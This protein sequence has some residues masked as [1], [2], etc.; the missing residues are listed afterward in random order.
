MNGHAVS[1]PGGERA[2]G[3]VV[4]IGSGL[5]AGIC[6]VLGLSIVSSTLVSIFESHL[7]GPIRDFWKFMPV[8]EAIER[9]ESLLPLLF[10]HHGH[11]HRLVVPRLFYLAEYSFFQGRNVFLLSASMVQQQAGLPH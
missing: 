1:T 3:T 8:L 6:L 4:R 11:G 5:G 7:L 10:E 9:G 2:A